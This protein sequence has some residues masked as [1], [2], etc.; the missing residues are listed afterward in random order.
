MVLDSRSEPL[1]IKTFVDKWLHVHLVQ[2]QGLWPVQ[3]Q[4]PLA[5]LCLWLGSGHVLLQDRRSPAM[6]GGSLSSV[7]GQDVESLVSRCLI[8]VLSQAFKSSC[9][10]RAAVPSPGQ[11]PEAVVK[12]AGP[13]PFL[14]SWA[15]V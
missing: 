2:L 15:L 9:R 11:G 14:N 3:P 1:W 12:Q 8:S 4:W 5:T 13:P 10:D 7:S 6:Q